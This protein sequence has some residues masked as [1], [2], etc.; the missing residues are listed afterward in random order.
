[1]QRTVTFSMSTWRPSWADALVASPLAPRMR[2][3][4]DAITMPR[5]N[6]IVPNPSNPAFGAA[7]AAIGKPSVRKLKRLLKSKHRYEQRIAAELITRL[8]AMKR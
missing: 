2:N 1:M 8:D 6:S 4:N 5:G 7:L 3:T